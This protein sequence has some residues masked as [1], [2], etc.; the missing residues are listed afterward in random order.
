MKRTADQAGHAGRVW[1]TKRQRVDGPL[2]VDHTSSDALKVTA[3]AGG[4]TVFKVD[5]SGSSITLGGAVSLTQPLTINSTSAGALDVQDGGSSVFKIDNSAN[6]VTIKPTSG[7]TFESDVFVSGAAAN[8]SVTSDD[9]TAFLVE[10]KSDGANVLVADP[11]TGIVTIGGTADEDYELFIKGEDPV[12]R[13]ESTR[14]AGDQ[15]YLQAGCSDANPC[16]EMTFH[17]DDDAA[18]RRFFLTQ[19]TESSDTGIIHWNDQQAE[20][21]FKVS[22]S[23]TAGA[24]TVDA[25]ANTITHNVATTMANTLTC[26]STTTVNGL[27]YFNSFTHLST[28]GN[29]TAATSP[30]NTQGDKPLVDTINVIKTTVSAT[31]AVTLPSAVEGLLCYVYNDSSNAVNIY[32]ASADRILIGSLA[33]NAAHSL[34]TTK[35]V[36]LVAVDGQDWAVVSSN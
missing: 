23:G 5:T 3:N 11:S 9:A 19:W 14:H 27:A 10:R 1:K 33:Q 13:L 26:S 17:D 16:L 34:A 2:H 22:T 8:L 32:P 30:D 21:D 15:W 18:N 6:T 20:W 31:D 36:L 4:T 35:Y 29:I 12:L 25:G 28:D 7:T 24:L